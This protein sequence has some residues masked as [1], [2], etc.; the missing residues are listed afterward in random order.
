VQGNV[1]KSKTLE[2]RHLVQTYKNYG[3]YHS[4]C[5][6]GGSLGLYVTTVIASVYM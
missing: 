6:N 2:Q 4:T 1:T 5:N 3:L